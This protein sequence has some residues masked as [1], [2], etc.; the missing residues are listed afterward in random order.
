M[1]YKEAAY[2]Y[3]EYVIFTDFPLQKLLHE[4]TSLLRYTNIDCVVDINVNYV[5][6]RGSYSVDNM[7][8]FP[9]GNWE[10]L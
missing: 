3:S 4:R 10:N 7:D 2:I 1:L 8:A 5:L 6:Q 9:V